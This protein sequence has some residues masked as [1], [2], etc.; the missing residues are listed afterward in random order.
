M[1]DRPRFTVH[2]EQLSK[3][4]VIVA[5]GGEVGLFTAPRLDEALEA[6]VAGQLRR[7]TT[8]VLRG[9]LDI[10]PRLPRG[11]SDCDRPSP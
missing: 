9:R 5:V 1:D 6:G 10:V 2:H 11:G 3:G 8:G 7:R 4:C